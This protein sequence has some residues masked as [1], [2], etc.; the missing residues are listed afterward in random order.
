MSPFEA[1][2]ERR[3]TARS[4]TAARSRPPQRNSRPNHQVESQS[5]AARSSAQL[6]QRGI[7]LAAEAELAFVVNWGSVSCALQNYA[8]MVEPRGRHSKGNRRGATDRSLRLAVSPRAIAFAHIR[9]VINIT[10]SL[11]RR[12]LLHTQTGAS[13]I[14]RET[15]R[16]PCYNFSRVARTYFDRMRC[17]NF[18]G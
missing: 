9:S 6:G 1:P 4:C 18:R 16:P 5:V 17:R 10:F 7:P 15:I 8:A 2:G 11:I 13:E 14:G 12:V 3:C